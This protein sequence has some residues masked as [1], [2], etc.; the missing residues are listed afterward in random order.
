MDILYIMNHVVFSLFITLFL[1]EIGMAFTGLLFYESYVKIKRYL[2]PMWEINGT[3]AIFYI[4]SFEAIYPKLLVSVGILY[5]VPVMVA[6]LLFI[7]RNAF[8]SYTEYANN[9]TSERAYFIIY[10]ISTLVI[11]FLVIS[12]FTSALSGIGININTNT[13]YVLQFLFNPFNILAF[14]S[15]VLLGF[16]ITVIVLSINKM[17]IS[18][19]TSLV[20]SIFIGLI[21]ISTYTNYVLNNI[22]GDIWILYSLIIILFITLFVLVLYIKKVRISNKMMLP[23]TFFIILIFSISQYPYIYGNQ[24]YINAYLT[25]GVNQAPILYITTFGMLFLSIS[26]GYLIYIYNKKERI[27]EK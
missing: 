10:S 14:I 9:I 15:L 17:R 22:L 13:L 16:C 3:F 5:L 25:Q 24:A 27:K 2:I 23:A 21:S 26:I 6:A 7:L 8:I 4:V 11:G 20:A 1:V 18:A 19:V 12:I